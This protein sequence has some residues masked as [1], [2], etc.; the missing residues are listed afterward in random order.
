MVSL[1]KGLKWQSQMLLVLLIIGGSYLAYNRSWPPFTQANKAKIKNLL[2]GKFKPDSETKEPGPPNQEDYV[3]NPQQP[4]EGKV[5]SGPFL[6]AKPD[7]NV[8]KIFEQEVYKQLVLPFDQYPHLYGNNYLNETRGYDVF[9]YAAG[10]SQGDVIP[11]Y[12]PP[13]KLGAGQSNVPG[14]SAID[15][16]LCE[17]FNQ[18]YGFYPPGGSCD[19]YDLFNYFDPYF[20]NQQSGSGAHQIGMRARAKSYRTKAKALASTHIKEVDKSNKVPMPIFSG[21]RLNDNNKKRKSGVEVVD[22]NGEDVIRERRDLI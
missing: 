17:A 9:P 8:R 5:M 22:Y 15:P 12:R 10:Y 4:L 2:Q 3:V 19:P 18:T 7:E 20:L 11:Y 16:G 14:S 1:I 6:S 13:I 21:R